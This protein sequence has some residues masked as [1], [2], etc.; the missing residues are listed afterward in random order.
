M[1]V[2]TETEYRTA[3]DEAIRLADAPAGRREAEHLSEAIQAVEEYEARRGWWIDDALR[4][5]T[6][7]A[8]YRQPARAAGLL[9]GTVANAVV[10][11]KRRMVMICFFG[12]ALGTSASPAAT[13]L[14][15]SGR[16]RAPGATDT[17]ES[18]EASRVLFMAPAPTG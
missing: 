15:V 11:I 17:W 9:T 6:W 1:R 14:G 8:V 18:P 16:F 3:I 12:S 5:S 2:E 10:M 13:C 4:L 7:I